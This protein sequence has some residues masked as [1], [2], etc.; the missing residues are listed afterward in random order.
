MAKLMLNRSPMNEK[1]AN[2]KWLVEA[3]FLPFRMTLSRA[4]L[5]NLIIL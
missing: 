1:K 5:K 4:H 2:K 3:K